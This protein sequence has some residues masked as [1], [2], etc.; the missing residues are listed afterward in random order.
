MQGERRSAL[1]FGPA[2]PR[3]RGIRQLVST[4]RGGSPAP[5]LMAA[6]AGGS[7]GRAGAWCSPLPR[8]AE[9]TRGAGAQARASWGGVDPMPAPGSRLVDVGT[10]EPSHSVSLYTIAFYLVRGLFRG[11]R[12][13]TG[14]NKRA[15]PGPLDPTSGEWLAIE[16]FAVLLYWANRSKYLSHKVYDEP[17]PP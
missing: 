12:S 4:A 6:G 10:P 2:A 11:R 5:R 1:T 9:E 8:A 14:R 16:L 15:R 3:L 7:G 13:E 17:I